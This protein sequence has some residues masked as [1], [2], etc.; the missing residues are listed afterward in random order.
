M[1]YQNPN[2]IPYLSLKDNISLNKIKDY[3]VIEKLGIKQLLK[4]DITKLSG[5]QRQR[6]A[7]ARALSN[8]PYILLADEPTGALDQNNSNKV[9]EI[10]RE[11]AKDKLVIIVSH[12]ASLCRKYCDVILF[13]NEGKLVKEELINN[14][15][16]IH[17]KKRKTRV[18][19]SITKLAFS[20]LKYK[21]K[22][23]FLASF[24]CSIGLIGVMLSLILSQGFSSFFKMQFDNSLNANSLYGYPR[25]R[26][27]INSISLHDV[28]DIALTYN[29]KWGVFYEVSDLMCDVMYEKEYIEWLNITNLFHYRVDESLNI[30]SNLSFILSFPRSYYYIISSLI[31]KP[32]Y[33]ESEIN[34]YI[35][36]NNIIAS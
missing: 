36:N 4:R 26:D 33:D 15:N 25:E 32:F 7:L 23:T 18:K 29:L 9:M 12:D 1:I 3:S 30:K 10:L 27:S 2:L 6:I 35:K 8:N 24:C 17:I 5:G 13:L 22:R 34:N 31:N 19:Q 16:S 11:E 28:Q 21:R 20:F 14:I